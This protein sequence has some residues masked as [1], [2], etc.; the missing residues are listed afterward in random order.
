MTSP[1]DIARRVGELEAR[2]G[3]GTKV[4]LTVAVIYT[5]VATGEQHEGYRRTFLVDAE[6]AARLPPPM[7][8]VPPG[9]DDDAD[10]L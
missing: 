5:D 10:V 2:A 1:R 3:A 8:W 6:A 9:C 4:P 7:P